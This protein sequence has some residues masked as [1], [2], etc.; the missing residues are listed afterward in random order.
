MN[1]FI[2][3]GAGFVGSHLINYLSKQVHK[4]TSFDDFSNSS[5]NNLE[6]YDVKIIRGDILNYSLLSK[7]LKNMDIVIHLAAQI[8]ITDSIKDPENTIKINVDGTKNIL[9]ACLENNIKNFIGI[10]TA[11]VF[12]NQ[13]EILSENSICLPISPYGESKLMMEEFIINFSKK[14]NFNSVILRFFNLYGPGQSPQYAGVIT[15]FLKNLQENKPLEIFGDGNQSRDFIHIDDAV[16][17]INST[18]KNLEGKSGRVYNIGSGTSTS[19]LQL[20]NL[21]LKLTEKEIQIQFKPEI[22]GDIVHSQTSIDLAKN[23][24]DFKSKISL[25]DGLSRFLEDF[26]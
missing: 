13:D 1:I 19:I 23:E 20:A 17:C 2:T 9:N 21:L 3:G 11:A 12:G 22:N 4:L 16:R 8:S 14:H 15:K 18:I 7:S 24:L 25:E 10:S 26:I 6:N 5:N